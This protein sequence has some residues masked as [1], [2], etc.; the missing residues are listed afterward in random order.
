MPSKT[1][2]TKPVPNTNEGY[3][4]FCP[5]CGKPISK[6]GL[7]EAC[8][9]PADAGFHVPV[10][11]IDPYAKVGKCSSPDIKGKTPLKD[12]HPVHGDPDV[13]NA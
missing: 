6:L 10:P 7:C 11:E 2:P 3:T 5:K 13:S 9:T 12:D 8:G 1:E 4:D